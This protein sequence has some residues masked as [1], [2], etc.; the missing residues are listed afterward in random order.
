MTYPHPDPYDDAMTDEPGRFA[1]KLSVDAWTCVLE[2]GVGKVPYDPDA[3][4]GRRTSTAIEM[5]VEPLDPTRGLIQRDTL[6]WT[7]EFRKVV[8]PSIEKLI[9]QIAEIRGLKEGQFNPLKQIDGL[10]VIGQYIER[11]E[12]DPDETWTTLAFTHVFASE[13]ECKDAYEEMEDIEI[14]TAPASEP[15]DNGADPERA[16]M[17]KFLPALWTQAGEDPDE[18]AEMI[19]AN[20]MLAAHF[21]RNSEEVRALTGEVPF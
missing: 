19:K 10:Y 12:N 16:Q 8:R 15:G 3:H 9:P 21:D 6:N 17:A 11:P 7:A 13:R 14:E 1:G 4:K 18:F 2:K 5:T 20:P